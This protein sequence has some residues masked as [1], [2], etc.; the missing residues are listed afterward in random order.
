[1][2][3][4]ILRLRSLRR[5]FTRHILT[6]KIFLDRRDMIMK[7]LL[8]EVLVSLAVLLL[9]GSFAIL[10]QRRRVRGLVNIDFTHRCGNGTRA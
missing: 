6:F 1:M 7:E 8:V 3:L 10:R 5:K 4:T 2:V 9:P